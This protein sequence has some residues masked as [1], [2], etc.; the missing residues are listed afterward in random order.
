[1]EPASARQPPGTRDWDAA[2]YDRISTPQQRWAGAVIDRLRL[3]GDE[4]VL[5][6][7]C[8]SGRVTGLLLDRLPHGHVIAVDG[9]A[10]MIAEAR[11]NLDPERTTLIRS[12]LMELELEEPVD[13]VFSNAVFHW[14][15]DHE[16]LF[17]ALAAALRP[18]GRL[19][20]QCGGAGNV[21]RFYASAAEVAA[22]ERF[23]DLPPGVDPHKFP[24][25]AETSEILAAAGFEA[26]EC[27]LEPRPVRPPEP[28]EFIRSVCLGAHL[29][30]LPAGR[31]EEYVDAVL[32]RL[33]PEPELDYV[34][35][36]ISAR[37]RAAPAP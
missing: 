33:G 7:G 21:A 9:S 6:A 10:A 4:T 27:G 32:E 26:I 34:R 22:Q 23:A 24:D 37:K 15:L 2:T 30:L 35:L 13:A 36:N 20:A 17:G 14:I 29:E 19:E 3:R 5:D 28:R 11:A 12:D 31:R 25:P 18:G 1:M 8:G 16:R